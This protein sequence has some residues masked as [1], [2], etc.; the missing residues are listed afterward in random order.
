MQPS[1]PF[2]TMLLDPGWEGK[3][4]QPDLGGGNAAANLPRPPLHAYVVAARRAAAVAR[5]AP[6]LPAFDGSRRDRGGKARQ[7]W[8]PPPPSVTVPMPCCRRRQPS[9]SPSWIPPPSVAV[10]VPP[11][12]RECPRSRRGGEAEG[13]RGEERRI[14]LRKKIK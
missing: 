11:P 10:A 6:G 8:M 14:G 2:L 7:G 1:P 12:R 4:R 5:A 13:E 3:G 9:A